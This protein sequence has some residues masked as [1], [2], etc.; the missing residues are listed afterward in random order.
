MLRI[1]T[2]TLK[3]LYLTVLKIPEQA[4]NKMLTFVTKRINIR[5]LLGFTCF[6]IH[7]ESL[8][9]GENAYP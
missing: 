7:V 2:L 3:N 6:I 5:Q 1:T 9:I 4:S 8:C